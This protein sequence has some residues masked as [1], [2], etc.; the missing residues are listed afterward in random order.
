MT[1]GVTPPVAEADPVGAALNDPAVRIRLL[2]AARAFLAG[3]IFNLPPPQRGPE[4]EVIVQK[5]GLR[6]W[7]RRAEY[8]PSRDIVRWLVAF[9]VNVT[10]EHV[11]KYTRCGTGPPPGPPELEELAADL[12]RPIGEVVADKQFV[13]ELL[14]RLP[15]ADREIIRLAYFEDLTFAEIG[16]RVGLTEN[17]AR[18]RH[19]RIIARLREL[20]GGTGEVQP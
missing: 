12:G 1:V 19:H 18:V 5:A 2:A 10:R 16:G 3:R 9:V 11:K 13:V 15:K 14:A 6:A 8:D 7:E 20:A 4:A 17:A